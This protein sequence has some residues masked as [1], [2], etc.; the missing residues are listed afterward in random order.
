MANKP[1][2]FVASWW[3]QR[4]LDVL[5][6]V[7]PA[8][9]SRLTRGRGDAR[10]GRVWPLGVGPGVISAQ[11]QDNYSYYCQA[12]VLL[13]PLPGAVWTQV[14]GAMA[15]E[16]AA[17]AKLLAGEFPLEVEA[18]FAAAGASLFPRS[19]E[20]FAMSCTCPT[21]D[22]PCRHTAAAC[23]AFALQIETQPLL[24][25]TLRG[26]TAEQITAELRTTWSGQIG[27]APRPQPKL[28]DDDEPDASTDDADGFTAVLRPA[29]FFVGRD[30]LERFRV[31]QTPPEGE[32]ALLKRLGNPPFA[33]D[34]EDVVAALAPVYGAATRYGL[35]LWQR[36]A[37]GR[38][39]VHP[40]AEGEPPPETRAGEGLGETTT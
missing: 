24:L 18:L 30:G 35:R 25:L 19:A 20:E 4:W 12:Q 40:T 23:Y 21:W 9:Q 13:Q 15:T 6:G 10:A 17:M 31:T 33:K 39:A 8:Y 11:V 3:A 1:K 5:E 26:R 27:G 16:A 29:S 2:P 7:G 14:L 22:A 28:T 34:H 37:Q 32:A 36:S 38:R